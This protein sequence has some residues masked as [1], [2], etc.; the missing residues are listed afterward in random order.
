MSRA[1]GKSRAAGAVDT[2]VTRA[3]VCGCCG[4]EILDGEDWYRQGGRTIC[5]RCLALL[6]EEAGEQEKLRFVT[7]RE[8]DFHLWYRFGIREWDRSRTGELLGI[9]REGFEAQRAA[10][11]PTARADL[12]DYCLSSCAVEFTDAFRRAHGIQRGGAA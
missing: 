9:L 8:A 5:E 1:A 10:G 4:R 7:G 11:Q 3:E 12:D 6:A 2:A